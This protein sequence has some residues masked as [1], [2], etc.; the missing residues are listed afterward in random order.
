MSTIQFLWTKIIFFRTDSYNILYGFDGEICLFYCK[1][2]SVYNYGIKIRLRTHYDLQA[3]LRNFP[4]E[5]F[6][7]KKLFINKKI[8]KDL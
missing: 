7:T 5:I 8:Y 3:V 6:L 2:T 4:C 1:W